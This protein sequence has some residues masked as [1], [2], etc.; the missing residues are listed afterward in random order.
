M[1]GP[2]L[3]PREKKRQPEARP[4]VD[5]GLQKIVD[6]EPPLCPADAYG[7]RAEHESPEPPL[8]EAEIDPVRAR[9]IQR[10]QKDASNNE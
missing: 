2:G 4:P 1:I 6:R 9:R 3:Q 5:V 8:V 7:K 10:E